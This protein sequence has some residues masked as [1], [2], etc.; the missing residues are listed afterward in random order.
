VPVERHVR[1]GVCVVRVTV[2]TGGLPLIEVSPM[3]DIERP[4]DA[5]R[6]SF[7]RGDAITAV[8]VVSR[9]VTAC[10]AR[11]DDQGDDP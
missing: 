5:R 9:F 3:L 1:T 8:S 6:Q 2:A 4:A 10:V 11:D 7:G